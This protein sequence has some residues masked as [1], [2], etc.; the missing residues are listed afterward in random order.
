MSDSK[1]RMTWPG[2][3]AIGGD[4]FKSLRAMS[5]QAVELGVDSMLAELVRIRASQLN[6]CAFCVQGHTNKARELGIAPGKITQLP[7]WHDAVV[8][9]DRER[10]ALAWTDTVTRMSVHDRESARAAIEAVFSEAEIAGLTAT[11]ANINAWNRIAG[12]LAFP[13]PP[14]KA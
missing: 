10:A 13:P 6:G 2:F 14:A 1:S 8:Y 3:E 7:A 5:E 11:I 9:D 12:A 4:I